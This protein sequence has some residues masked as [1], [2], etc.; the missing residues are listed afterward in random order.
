MSNPFYNYR[1][2]HVSE[3]EQNLIFAYAPTRRLSCWTCLKAKNMKKA[4]LRLLSLV[5]YN[6]I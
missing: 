5:L 1:S 3:K 6:S 2:Q 4:I